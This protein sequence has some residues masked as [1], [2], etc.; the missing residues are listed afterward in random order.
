MNPQNGDILENAIA[1]AVFPT[2][3][4]LTIC[5]ALIIATHRKYKGKNTIKAAIISGITVV[6]FF[7]FIVLGGENI[8]KLEVENR[9]PFYPIFIIGAIMVEIARRT[10]G[11]TWN[12][13]IHFGQS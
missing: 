7:G 4:M 5:I 9:S 1:I 3:L 10:V 2:I 8:H 13:L 12:E 6:L 11:V